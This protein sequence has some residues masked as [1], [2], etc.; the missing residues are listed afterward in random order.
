M[1]SAGGYI[2]V[3][4][5]LVT[6]ILLSLFMTLLE[7]S[8]QDIIRMQVECSADMALQSALAQ[9]HRQMQE[10]YG[11]FFIDTSYGTAD[12]ASIGLSRK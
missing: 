7:A 10:Q 4:L 12:P 6:G 1:K 11:L 5:A 2:T 3:Y 9:Y 8:R